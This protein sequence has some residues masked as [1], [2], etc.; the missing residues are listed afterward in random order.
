M[1]INGMMNL[2]EFDI[3]GNENLT[4][5]GEVIDLSEL[6]P[7]IRT[8]GAHGCGFNAK[9]EV[10][11]NSKR[12]SDLTE[13][14]LYANHL[15]GHFDFRQI[16]RIAPNLREFGISSN[17]FEGR[18]EIDESVGTMRGLKRISIENNHFNGPFPFDS[19]P[20]VMPSLE[21]LDIGNNEFEGTLDLIPLA[22]MNRTRKL[23][24]GHNISFIVLLECNNY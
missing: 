6:P 12:F 13:L 10:R 16:Q 17:Q 14:F 19:L 15:H 3:R 23:H 8:F 22:K 2:R 21:Y 18:F 9:L 20:R 1:D 4:L 11:D 7:N 5:K 24:L